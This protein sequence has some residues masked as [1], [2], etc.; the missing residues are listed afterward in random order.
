MLWCTT[1][2]LLCHPRVPAQ[3]VT[4][5]FPPIHPVPIRSADLP[6]DPSLPVAHVVPEPE[7]GTPVKLV[8]NTQSRKS[9]E[10]GNL[11][12]LDGDAVIY[13]R[14]YIVH[15]DHVTY[16]DGTGE[17]EASGHL[18]IDGGPDDEHF[19][20][21]HGHLN[22]EHDT[23]RIYDVV[24]TLGLG[25][26][27]RGRMVF[28]AP[29][30]FAI[31]AR[32]VEQLGAGRYKV[33]HGTITSCM[34]P[35]PDWRIVAEDI[36]LNNGVAKSSGGIFEMFR[37]P[38]VYLP[39]VTHP[40]ADTRNS[41]ILL[42]YFGDNTT[43]GFVVGEGFY[44]TLGRSA[45]LTMATQFWSKRG[46]APNGIFRYRGPG[47]DFGIVRFHSLL[48]R[49]YPLPNGTRINQGGVDLAA[50]GRYD[51]SP[52]T[53]AVVDA[54]YLSSYI[55]R[56]VFEEEY[57][58]AINSEV[59]SQ[60]FVTHE[61]RDM[62]T[63]LR[64]NRYQNFQDAN[65]PGDEVRILH[66]PVIEIE[67]ADHSLEGSPL[68][69]SVSGSAAAL[70]RFEYPNFRTTAS[71]PRVDFWPRFSV[72]LHAGGWNFRPEAGVRETWY[73]KSQAPAGLE[74]IPVVRKEGITRTAVEAGF[75]FRPPALERDFSSPWLRHLLGGEVRHTIEPEFAYRYV[76][77]VNNFR[78][79]LRFDDVDVVSNTNEA[80]YGL[81]QRLFLRHLH[82]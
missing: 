10:H 37:V 48:D 18:M 22:A 52:N 24:G 1:L 63:S 13:Y 56:L 11:Y 51:L 43:K 76:T 16:N 30:P 33:I 68:V 73:G 32:A 79:I 25:R 74:Q 35:K 7:K 42:P 27:P 58:I 61:E 65:I 23:G 34:L 67:T 71:V 31:T 81:T 17:V 3:T 82:P 29:N 54:E 38:L 70:S 62:W 9:L 78:Y 15:A 14:N 41:G 64:M 36:E 66:L 6:D 12:T 45:D 5:E 39:Y 49:G 20:A 19:V 47:M 40:I 57:A 53:T 55:Y 80:E 75:Q 28:T 2:L 72:P 21:S 59:K 4:T 26:T 69:W 50:D 46:W 60:A 77:G 8:A 44:Q